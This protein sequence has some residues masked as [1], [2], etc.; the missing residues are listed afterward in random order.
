MYYSVAMM[1]K[2]ENK[3]REEKKKRPPVHGNLMDMFRSSV[4]L[5]AL[6]TQFL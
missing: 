2:I 5:M 1:R 3:K 6:G 4:D